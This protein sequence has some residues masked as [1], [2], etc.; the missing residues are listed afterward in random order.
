MTIEVTLSSTGSLMLTA[1]FKKTLWRISVHELINL[2]G[3][4]LCS[5]AF[6]SIDLYILATSLVKDHTPAHCHRRICIVEG[7]NQD[8]AKLV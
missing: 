2:R 7:Y 8:S 5:Y 1:K 6:R 4:L 3:Y